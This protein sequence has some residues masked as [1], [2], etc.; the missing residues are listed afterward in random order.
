MLSWV[1]RRKVEIP[2]QLDL[3][4]HIL[5]KCEWPERYA[6]MWVNKT[7]REFVHSTYFTKRKHLKQLKRSF[8]ITFP[9]GKRW[10]APDYEKHLFQ[11]LSLLFK[12]LTRLLRNSCYSRGRGSL[13]FKEVWEA[14]QSKQIVRFYRVCGYA[15]GHA[16]PKQFL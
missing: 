6:L 3:W 13:W 16:L 10:G 2:F 14:S 8:N 1:K 12:D 4:S 5:S 15:C 7:L 11:N 9:F